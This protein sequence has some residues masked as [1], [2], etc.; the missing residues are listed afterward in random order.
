MLGPSEINF[1]PYAALKES[2]DQMFNIRSPDEAC[3][4]YWKGF[5]SDVLSLKKYRIP[6]ERIRSLRKSIRSISKSTRSFVEDI[7]F[8][9]R[10]YT[11]FPDS[12]LPCKELK[13]YEDRIS[14]TK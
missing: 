4:T 14:S 6:T 10:K 7:R 13:I 2:F 8:F 12:N 3:L 5:G 1:L 11:I 9:I